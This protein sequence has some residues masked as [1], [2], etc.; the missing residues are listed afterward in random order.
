MWAFAN[1]DQI[2]RAIHAKPISAIGKFDECSDRIVYNHNLGSMLPIHEEL[3]HKGAV[4][5][6][7]C[8]FAVLYCV[9]LPW[10]SDYLSKTTLMRYACSL[11]LQHS[12]PYAMK[13][14]SLPPHHFCPGR[15]AWQSPPP[16]LG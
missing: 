7:L 9:L 16:Q 6:C 14:C 1:S 12:T 10:K 3:L 5:H 11:Q 13:C 2:R 8:P 15:V 4:V